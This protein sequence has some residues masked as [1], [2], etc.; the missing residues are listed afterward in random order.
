MKRMKTIGLFGIFVT[1]LALTGC[2]KENDEVV[3]CSENE[4]EVITDVKLTF[5]NTNDPMDV[6][7]VLAQD[8]DGAGVQELTIVDTIFLDTNKTYILTLEVTNN[9]ESPGEDITAE[10]SGE[11]DEHQ[12]FYSFTNNAFA[13]PMGDGNIDN[14]SDNVIY[15]DMDGNGDPLGLS[16]TWTTSTTTVNAGSF[17]VMLQHQPD[18]KT[19]TTGASDGDTDFE[20]EFVMFIN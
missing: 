3:P 5:T 7:E 10:I 16:T 6:V 19:S 2:K 8:P 15:N 12:L 18:I 11:A 17:K 9:L 13:N 14:A 20:L 4:E 1:G